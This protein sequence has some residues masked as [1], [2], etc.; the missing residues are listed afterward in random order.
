MS[1][2]LRDVH[3]GLTVCGREWTPEQGAQLDALLNVEPNPDRARLNEMLAALG[4]PAQVRMS[5]DGLGFDTHGWCRCA[6][7]PDA[8]TWVRYERWTPAGREGHGYVCPTCR[9]LVQTG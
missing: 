1:L 2:K 6:T 4:T 9:L 3:G 5:A 7:E 8:M